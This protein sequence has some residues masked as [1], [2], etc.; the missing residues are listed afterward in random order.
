[1]VSSSLR[2]LCVSWFDRLDHALVGF[3]SAYGIHLLRWAVAIVY[4][5]FGGLKLINA[6]PAAELVVRTVFWL[7]PQQSLAFIG[8]WE[9]LIGMGLLVTHPLVLRATLFLLWLQAAGTFQVFVLLPQEA[10]QGGNPL[11]PTLEGQYAFKNLVLIAAGLV[12]GSTVRR[13]SVL[14][15]M[16]TPARRHAQG[17]REQP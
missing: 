13:D 9:M 14:R 3:M 4:L 15:S 6:S 11:L 17:R 8:S 12:I 1:M 7:P 16:P 2:T 5:W 10:F